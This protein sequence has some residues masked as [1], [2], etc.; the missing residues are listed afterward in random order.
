MLSEDFIKN[1]SSLQKSVILMSQ[2]SILS[3]LFLIFKINTN[4]NSSTWPTLFNKLKA[5]CFLTNVFI[6]MCHADHLIFFFF[7]FYHKYE[8]PCWTT[9]TIAIGQ[10]FKFNIKSAFQKEKYFFN[11]FLQL[12]IW[13]FVIHPFQIYKFIK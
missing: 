9:H 1:K 12:F 3:F 10:N 7:P 4:P 13:L 2:E 11:N 8:L 6:T 5:T